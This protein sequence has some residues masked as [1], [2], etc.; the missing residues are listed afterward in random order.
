MKHLPV[1]F[2][3]HASNIG[4]SHIPLS[5]CRFWN[6]SGRPAT[7]TVPGA[8]PAFSYPWLNPVTSGFT[9]T[10]LYKLTNPGQSRAITEAIFFR[11]EASSS[12]V[13]LWAGLSLDIF[14]HFREKGASIIIERIN[15]HRATSRNILKQA[16]ET[17]GIPTPEPFPQKEIDD[18]NHKLDI[19][20][21]IFC[22]SPMVKAS[23]LENNIPESKL[24]PSSYGWAPERFPS[25]SPDKKENPKPVF[26]FAGTICMRKGIPLLLEAWN[27]AALDAELVLCG[28]IDE[29]MRQLVEQQLA[30]G[31]VRHIAYTR[32]IGQIFSMADAFV[33]PSLEEGG[34]MV[35]YEAMAHGIPPI[36][37]AMGA[38]AIAENGKNGIVLPDLDPDSWA[39]AL[40]DMATNPEKRNLLGAAA[41]QRAMDFTWQNV[42]MQRALL[43]EK[44]YP[45]LWNQTHEQA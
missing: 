5:L 36:V 40:T 2:G 22:P 10:A 7:L 37:T 35:T 39:A 23:M 16:A 11:R 45:Q 27:R 28:K 38:G 29:P 24:L 31:T 44:R 32:N 4:N 43:L 12:P 1:L 15:C 9:R 42:A 8:D 3:Y 26:L 34:P 18:E 20:D 33:F 6:E 21:A 25:I 41:Q 14:R 19:A 30:T 17:W 13:Y